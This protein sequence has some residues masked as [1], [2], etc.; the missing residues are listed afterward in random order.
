MKLMVLGVSYS[1]KV[2]PR[3]I[4]SRTAGHLAD[5][6]QAVE[7]AEF[8]V[9]VEVRK[10]GRAEGR[11]GR[12]NGSGAGSAPKAPSSERH[13]PPSRMGRLRLLR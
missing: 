7:E 4:S 1:S 9:D 13:E 5:S 6:A 11:H 2:T 8:G 10:I 3:E 12:V